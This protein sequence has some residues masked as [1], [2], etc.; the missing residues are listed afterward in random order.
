MDQLFFTISFTYEVKP[1]TL[2]VDLCADIEMIDNKTFLVR[3]VRRVNL[4]ESSLL[5][6]LTLIHTE[7]CWL[8]SNTGKESNISKTLGEAITKHLKQSYRSRDEMKDNI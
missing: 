2:A 5:P 3:N 7:G 4:E 1:K 8:H 6:V